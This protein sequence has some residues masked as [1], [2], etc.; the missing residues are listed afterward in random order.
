MPGGP[1]VDPAPAPLALQPAAGG[2]AADQ[3]AVVVAQRPAA[4]AAPADAGSRVERLVASGDPRDA[5]R[6]F[7]LIDRCMR[8]RG[9]D[10]VAACR[11]IG[12]AQRRDRLALLETAARAG[13]PGA[14][15]AWTAE[16][17]FGDKSA[18]TQ[19][20][21]DPLVAEWVRQAVEMIRTAAARNDVAA[22]TQLGWLTVHWDMGDTER[23]GALVNR[24]AEWQPRSRHDEPV[25]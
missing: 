20:P 25:E 13:V 22:I 2:R 24:P 9:G 19:R 17:P 5:Y 16:G 12:A 10:A 3:E 4:L 8:A 15:T 18:L 7:R 21:D 23:L 14:V 1:I 6:A 11:G